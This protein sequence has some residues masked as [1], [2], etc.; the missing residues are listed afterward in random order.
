MTK[1]I[2]YFAPWCPD[3]AP[4]VTELKRLNIDYEAI[5]ITVSGSNFKPF[6]RL[7]DRH[8]AFD[9]AKHNGYI[10]IPAL[11]LADDQVILDY[12]Q[13]AKIFAHN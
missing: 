6:L 10:G 9:D 1:P 11:V 7:R 5:D 12:Q 2:L 4:F 8:S 13:L 3:T